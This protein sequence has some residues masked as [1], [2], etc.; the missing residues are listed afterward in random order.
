MQRRRRFSLSHLV[1]DTPPRRA[2]WGRNRKECSI[3]GQRAAGRR[4]PAGPAGARLRHRKLSEHPWDELEILSFRTARAVARMQQ[5]AAP[6]ACA[7]PSERLQFLRSSVPPEL[8]SSAPA[9]APAPG[10]SFFREQGTATSSG[11]LTIK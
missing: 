10:G 8:S 2:Q 5:D 6:F 7:F 9:S 3:P 1:S 11:L 4:R